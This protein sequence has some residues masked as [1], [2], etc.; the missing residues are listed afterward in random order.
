MDGS[1]ELHLALA[2][3]PHGDIPA[4]ARGNTAWYPYGGAEHTTN[5]FSWI[6]VPNWSL[7]P[8]NGQ[9]PPH[10]AISGRQND[11][12][13]IW[14]AMARTQKGSQIPAKA[15]GTTCWYPYGGKEH[16]TNTFSWIVYQ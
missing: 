5:D 3:T 12:A 1:G 9:A 7:Q 4:K 11:G 14:A 16:T 2:H 15:S 13:Q 6:V 8:S 10:N